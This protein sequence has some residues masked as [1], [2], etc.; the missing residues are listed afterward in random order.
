MQYN[1]MQ[2]Y[3]QFVLHLGWSDKNNRQ[4]IN[5]LLNEWSTNSS[6]HLNVWLISSLVI[7]QNEKLCQRCIIK[8]DT[9]EIVCNFISTPSIFY[10]VSSMVFQYS[11]NV[12]HFH[13]LNI[14]G[15]HYEYCIVNVVAFQVK[16]CQ[17]RY[18]FGTLSWVKKYL[19]I[20]TTE[21]IMLG[22]A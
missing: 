8:N 3:D 20:T 18:N 1:A 9:V 12:C 11:P 4:F 16:T 7:D 21:Q 15:L 6:I 2:F 10:I 17:E 5:L 22:R 19:L 13:V 14:T